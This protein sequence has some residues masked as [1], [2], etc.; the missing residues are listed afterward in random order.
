MGSALSAS[1]SRGGWCVTDRDVARSG[2]RLGDP[3]LLRLLGLRRRVAR[4]LRL[5]ALGRDLHDVPGEAGAPHEV[6]QP[7]ADVELVPAQAVRGRARERMVVVV[8]RLA[9]ARQRKPEHVRR[10][11][12][13]LE[14]AL[15]EEVAD[16]VHAPR[17]VVLEEDAGEAAPDQAGQRALPAHR[18]Q[19]A[20]RGG[21]E[22]AVERDEWEGA[23]D[24][25]MPRSSTSSFAYFDFF[26]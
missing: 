10:V 15:A 11:V 8:P 17:D 26:A 7:G 9:E 20:D 4:Q 25:R 1:R 23:F 13:D 12:V 16:A 14:P 19:A 22:Q 3:L 5:L 21:D 24:D 2:D 6:D 18:E